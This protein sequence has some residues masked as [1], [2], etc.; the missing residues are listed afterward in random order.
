[1]AGSYAGLLL[2]QAGHEVLLFDDSLGK[3]KPC[4]GGVTGKALRRMAWLRDRQLP[5]TEIRTMRLMARDGRKAV[6]PLRQ[7]IRIFCRTTL[8]ASIRDLACGFGTRLLDERATGLEA[9]NGGWALRTSAGCHELDFVIGADGATSTIR[10]LLTGR[11]AAE[12][13]SLALGF[14][15]PGEY[16]TD[17]I[18]TEFQ[19]SGFEGYIWSFPR[20]D[21]A[22]VGIL[23]WLPATN[24]AE[25]RRRV[26]RFIECSYP[27]AGKDLRFYA[28][29]IPC[30]S[31]SRLI[32]QRVCGK[33]WALLG[34]AAG[35]ADAIT[36]EG[37]Y[38][39]LR[40]AELIADSLSKQDPILYEGFWRRDFG[41]DLFHAAAWRDR[42]YTGNLLFQAFTRRAIQ[43]IR[44]SRTVRRLTDGLISGKSSYARIRHQV[45]INSPRILVEAL[46]NKLLA[47][48]SS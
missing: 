24:A 25:L 30:L 16:H 6:L 13:L 19:E 27:N 43:S 11:Y 26:L 15:M 39:A 5:H 45:L 44:H 38:Y 14:Y 31:R 22:S 48:Q 17:T 2:S 20:V 40:S 28:A 7:P 8:D 36:A 46:C 34:D 9:N 10:G 1:M 21:H 12:D 37:I 29:R 47:G 4:G 41:P 33:N 23:R 18:I 42:F 35:F 32:G 3:E